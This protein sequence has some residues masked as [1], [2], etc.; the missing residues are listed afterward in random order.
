MGPHLLG[1]VTMVTTVC[2][3]WDQLVDP[4]CHAGIEV[5]CIFIEL[6][7]FHIICLDTNLKA[8]TK[9]EST[10]D[11]SILILVLIASSKWVFILQFIWVSNCG[12]SSR[13]DTPD[14][15]PS[16]STTPTQER[17]VHAETRLAVWLAQMQLCVCWLQTFYYQNIQASFPSFH[18]YWLTL[19]PGF[20]L[21]P[22]CTVPSAPP[23][24]QLE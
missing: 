16:V 14:S 19:S 3:A 7:V 23:P 10:A 6:S 15:V 4:D 12:G 11:I 20:L 5:T 9:R 24:F 2:P 17:M 21:A 18:A 13:V 22:L 8:K 1:F